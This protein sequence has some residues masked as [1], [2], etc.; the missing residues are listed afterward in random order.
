MPITR[1]TSRIVAI[2]FMTLT[3]TLPILLAPAQHA[4]APEAD[5]II[6]GA[7]ISGLSAALEA[8]RGGARVV[9]VDMAS[10]FGGHAVMSEGELSIIDTP[11]QES[12]NIRD[13]PYLAYQDFMEWGEDANAAWMRYYVQHSRREIYFQAFLGWIRKWPIFRRIVVAA[14]PQHADRDFR[15]I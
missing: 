13:S 3:A 9:V 12:R 10:V 4:A 7:G 15:W 11:L 2:G 1:G 8:A 6:M 14:Q 5:V